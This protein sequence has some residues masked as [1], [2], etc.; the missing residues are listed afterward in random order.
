MDF[1]LQ[2]IETTWSK[3]SRGGKAAARRNSVPAAFPLPDDAPPFVHTVKMMEWDDFRPR[4]WV[5]R[6]LPRGIGAEEEPGGLRVDFGNR[7]ALVLR[8]GR[9]L[10]RQWTYRTGGCCGPKQ[11]VLC[12]LNVIYGKV[13]AESFL[14]EP[15]RYL[16]D[17]HPLSARRWTVGPGR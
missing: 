14:H 1:A 13:R 12:T 15:S 2:L 3:Q 6:E 5:E 8:P 7:P 9:S 16:D 4:A 11:Y 17:R 10:R